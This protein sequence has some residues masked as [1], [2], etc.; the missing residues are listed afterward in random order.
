MFSQNELLPSVNDPACR[1]VP[2]VTSGRLP[3]SWV[4]SRGS[5]SLFLGWFTWIGFLIL[6]L[7]P[8]A[9][10][11]DSRIMSASRRHMDG[12]P[13]ISY[14]LRRSPALPSRVT[15]SAHA[16]PYLRFRLT[17]RFHGLANLRQGSFVGGDLFAHSLA[18]KLPN[19]WVSGSSTR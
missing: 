10:P 9:L 12:W 15:S 11:R 1:G 16:S 3:H 6:G 19:S 18:F 4:G 17:W 7:N 13:A 8:I 5:A 14:K 2:G